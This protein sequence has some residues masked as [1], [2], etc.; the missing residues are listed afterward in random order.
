[1]VFFNKLF[2]KKEKKEFFTCAKILCVVAALDKSISDEKMDKILAGLESLGFDINKF[3]SEKDESKATDIWKKLFKESSEISYLL[4]DNVSNN[5]EEARNVFG[6]NTITS[7]DKKMLLLI[8]AREIAK[9]SEDSGSFEETM[10]MWEELYSLSQILG[11]KTEHANR[12][13]SQ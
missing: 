11:I 10:K 1:M 7:Y 6:I 8:S 5:I 13:I 4:R 9:I 3:I 12:I 2:G